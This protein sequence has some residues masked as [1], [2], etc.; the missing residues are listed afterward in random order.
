MQS[1]L[2][3]F[4]GSWIKEFQNNA[5][6]YLATPNGQ[7]VKFW[8]PAEQPS[9]VS[10]KPTIE[11]LRKDGE[12]I[13]KEIRDKDGNVIDKK[14]VRKA[15]WRV[16]DENGNEKIFSATYGGQTS[17]FGRVLSRI[18]IAIQDKKPY[19]GLRV[20]K[21]GTGM[22]TKYDLDSLDEPMPEK[23]EHVVDE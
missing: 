18:Q 23:E 16:I 10:Y 20:M 6:T 13:Y 14:P 3:D 15:K 17:L 22:A 12:I 21:T 9:G 2:K 4:D 11:I 7:W 8:I 19:L 5:G 1:E